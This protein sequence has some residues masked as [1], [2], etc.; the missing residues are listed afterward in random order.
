MS[1]NYDSYRGDSSD[2][3]GGYLKQ[4]LNNKKTNSYSRP[5]DPIINK[6]LGSLQENDPSKLQDLKKQIQYLLDAF[7]KSRIQ[8]SNEINT[9]ERFV[10]DFS[11]TQI[12]K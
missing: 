3:E 12:E 2:D 5:Q 7:N 11:R 9:Y 6:N 10:S 4:A 8:F 1:D